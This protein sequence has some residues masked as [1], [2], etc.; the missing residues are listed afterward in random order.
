MVADPATADRALTARFLRDHPVEAARSVEQLPADSAAEMLAP[1]PVTILTALFDHLS[2]FVAARMIDQVPAEVATD[3]LSAM[4]PAAAAAALAQMD[5]ERR[6]AWLARLDP[7]IANELRSLLEYPPDTAGRLMSRRLG[8]FRPDMGVPEA[9]QRLRELAVQ[10]ARTLFLV[11]DEGRLAGRVSVQRLA[12]APLTP[13]W[14]ILLSRRRI[15]WTRSPCAAS[16]STCS[17]APD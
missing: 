4:Q 10:D 11:D 16:W 12:T 8:F 3:T 13:P 5:D 7:A 14:P 17:R 1:H 2:P 15:E 6:D 9:S